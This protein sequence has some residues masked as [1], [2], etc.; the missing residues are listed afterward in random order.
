MVQ[1]TGIKVRSGLSISVLNM[2]GTTD[3]GNRLIMTAEGMSTPGVLLK[4]I[5]IVIRRPTEPKDT[6]LSTVKHIT[7]R[8]T[9]TIITAIR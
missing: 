3:T 6:L 4:N 2:T 5:M 7:D 8:F 1:K 9:N